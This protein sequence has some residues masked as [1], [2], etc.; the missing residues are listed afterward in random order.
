M[1]KKYF[2]LVVDYQRFWLA[3]VLAEPLFVVTILLHFP[4]LLKIHSRSMS[5]CKNRS[6]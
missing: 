4:L 1:L 5:G 2:L 3:I 6:L